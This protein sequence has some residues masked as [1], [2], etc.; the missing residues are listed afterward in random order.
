MEGKTKAL[1]RVAGLLNIAAAILLVIAI[2]MFWGLLSSGNLSGETTSAE[3]T[4]EAAGQAAAIF[5]SLIFFLPIILILLVPLGAIDAISG[6]VIGFHCLKKAP[7]RGT[8][9]YSLI[10]KILTVP[11]FGFAIIL[12]VALGDVLE[13]TVPALFPAVF[14][15]YLLLLVV[16]H[17][18][19]WMANRSA[20]RD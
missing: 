6:L 18:F 9:I 3:T 20:L 15:G 10:L 2:V 11:A 17:V 16:A 7:G 1:S 8:V 19:E 4:E 5:V 14:G 13:S 12:I